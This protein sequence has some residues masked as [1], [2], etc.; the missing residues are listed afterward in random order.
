MAARSSCQGFEEM[1]QPAG[2]RLLNRE[3]W[4]ECMVQSFGEDRKGLYHS[5][6]GLPG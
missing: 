3:V 1:D 5:Q 6:L 4:L 2:R